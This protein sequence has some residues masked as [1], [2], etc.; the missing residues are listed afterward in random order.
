LSYRLPYDWQ[1]M[2]QFLATRAIPGVEEITSTSYQRTISIDGVNGEFAL[3]FDRSDPSANLFVEFPDTRQLL[4]IVEKVRQLFDFAADSAEID[5]ALCRDE[6]LKGIVENS[7]GLRVPG[8]WDGF[9]IAVRAI[10]GQQVSVKAASTLMTRIAERHGI[11]YKADDPEVDGNSLRRIF[12]DA[13][14]LAGADL[15]KLG[16][17]GQRISAIHALANAVSAK[18]LEFDGGQSIETFSE[19]ICKIKGIGEW[20]AQ[21]V[22]LR[23]LRH[24]DAFPHG[25]LILQRAAGFPGNALTARQLLS[26]AESWRPWRAYAVM[27]LW[28]YYQQ[29]KQ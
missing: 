16:I 13:K 14:T 6:F 29:I 8:C 20:T 9:E 21:Y 10:V 12:P 2:L 11:S 17:T 1:S 24:P 27:L 22:A 5:R 3:V 18:E 26:R 4:K 28:R 15:S 19:R 7:P 25:D 23:A